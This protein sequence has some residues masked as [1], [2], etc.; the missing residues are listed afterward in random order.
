MVNYSL[1]QATEA[2]Q[3]FLFTVVHTAM[4]PVRL[5]NDP[6]KIVDM[7]KGLAEYKEK[8]PAEKV[9]VIQYDGKDV[10]RLRVVR[11]KEEIYIGGIQL[12]PEFQ[13]KGIGSSIMRDIINEAKK[14][15]TPITLEVHEVN[16]AANSFYTKLGFKFVKQEGNQF[17]LT[18]TFE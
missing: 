10:G 12:L 18:Y 3:P 15:K 1:R 8:Y 7:E 11:S 4:S 5:A 13:G 9:Q 2:D 17:V 14:T 6:D 16:K